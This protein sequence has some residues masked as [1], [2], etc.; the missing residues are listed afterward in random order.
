MLGVGFVEQVVDPCAELEVVVH[1]V[2]AVQREHAEAGA[3]VIVLA[4]DV[5]LVFGN[6]VL[7]R[8]QPPQCADAP[9]VAAVGQAQA[10][11]QG[12]HLR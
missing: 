2:G 5:P 1:L 7:R 8:H 12:R 11:F 4:D 10:A 6:A 9:H 3:L